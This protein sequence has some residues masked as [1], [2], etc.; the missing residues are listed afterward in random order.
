LPA[1][2]SRVRYFCDNHSFGARPDKE[3]NMM[4]MR[5]EKVADPRKRTLPVFKE[6]ESLLD[7]IRTRAFEM[8]S[9][10][11]FGEG[12]ALDDWLAAEREICWPAGELVE[13][14]KGYVLSLTLPGFEPA[15]VSITTT[16]R[17]VIVHAKTKIERKGEEEAKK[18][19]KGKVCWSE[20][21]SNDVYRRVELAKDIDVQSVSA[22]LENGILKIV[23]AKVETKTQKPVQVVPVSS[24][25]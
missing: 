17:E 24:A 14:D 16:P 13:Q 22:S 20:F 25:A 3:R 11:G 15:D 19:A 4:D 1:T 6:V 10:R 5:V 12:H 8:F 2:I 18:G 7:R 21:R 23:A 9:G